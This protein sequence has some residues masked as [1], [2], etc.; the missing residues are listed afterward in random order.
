MWSDLSY[1]LRALVRRKAVES[2]M[3]DELRF[4]FARQVEN[5]VAAGMGRTDAERRARMEFG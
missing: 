2:E 1:R 5:Y 3:N 4:H